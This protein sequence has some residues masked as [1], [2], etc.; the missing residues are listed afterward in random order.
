LSYSEQEIDEIVKHVIGAN[1]L[2][3]APHINDVSLKVKGLSD[4]EIRKVED[5]LPMVF[6]IQQAFTVHVLGKETL[7]RM[8][9]SPA[10]YGSPSFNLLRSLS[11]SESDIE[12]ANEY[13][14]GT[15]TVEGAPHLKKEHYPVFDCANK[16]GPKGTR[17]IEYMAH[18][19]MMA[20]A[21][22][23]LSGSISKTINMPNEASITDVQRVYLEGWRLGLKSLALYRDGSKMV[24][25]L[26]TTIAK[27]EGEEKVT[28]KPVR[29]HLPDER[30]SI[31]HKFKIGN[32]EG[33]LTVG[34]YKDGT[35]G[36]LFITMSKQ[37]STLSGLMDAFATGVSIALQYGVPL[38]VLVNKFIHT[39]FEPSG[40]TN[41]PQIRS[42]KSITDYIF[43]WMALKFLPK[44]ALA[45]IGINGNEPQ[46]SNGSGEEQLSKPEV[47]SVEKPLEVRRYDV[48]SDAPACKDCGSLMMRSGACYVCSVCGSTSG[49]S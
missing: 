30:T 47:F 6:D 25:P 36:E 1:T 18:V 42:A 11:F 5:A 31:T 33:Y 7:E 37:G 40:W 21:Q 15:Q 4:E 27:E 35:P 20:A 44:E 17:Y 23:L 22:P 43:R 32:Q 12:K 41:N 16:C 9:F 24:Q 2:K 19:K 10:Q 39:R 49:C 28:Y 38:E 13:V 34:L 8:G 14:C 29:R 46:N 45:E 3:D 26:T 48:R